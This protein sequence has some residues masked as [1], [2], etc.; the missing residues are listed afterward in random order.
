MARKMKNGVKRFSLDDSPVI[1]EN[2]RILDQGPHAEEQ[3]QQQ[4]TQIEDAPQT[5]VQQSEQHQMKGRIETEKKTT[6]QETIPSE[7]TTT[8]TPAVQP[9][10]SAVPQP[11]EAVES[12]IT[13]SRRAKFSFT[14]LRSEKG[15]KVMLPMDYYFK[16]VRLKECT[17]KTLQELSVQGVMEFIDKYVH[18]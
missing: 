9:A 5:N 4:S 6:Q 18:D 14:P 16:L 15:V 3:N 7:N 1:E 17:G 13:S 11:N 10:T 12:Q 2:E 8:R